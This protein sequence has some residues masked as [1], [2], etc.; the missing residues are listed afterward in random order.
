MRVLL[1]ACCFA[2]AVGQ[3]R[4]D[5]CAAM[6]SN[7]QAQVAD[8]AVVADDLGSIRMIGDRALAGVRECPDSALLWYLAVRSAEILGT[9]FGSQ[10]FAAPGGLHQVVEE[11][12][13]HAPNSAPIVTVAARVEGST[14]MA[15]QALALDSNYQPARRALAEAVARDGDIEAGLDLA[16]A[17]NARGPMHLTRAR[18]LLAAKRYSE[19]SREAKR[20]LPSA[21]DELSASA[22]LYRDSNEVL[23]LAL[24]GLHQRAEAKRALRAAAS[25][26]SAA[27][28]AQLAQ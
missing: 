13:A 3:A 20:V 5:P 22:D 17:S 25:A 8:L 1:I 6:E 24:L 19:A 2:S 23:G 11:A 16:I 15:R 26:G 28:R 27:A 10:T 12:L 21:P 7:L 14:A 4:Q 18:I 9:R